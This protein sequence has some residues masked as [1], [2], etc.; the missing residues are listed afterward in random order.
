M[1][2]I[3]DYWNYYFYGQEIIKLSPCSKY[4]N[5]ESFVSILQKDGYDYYLPI[6]YS[7]IKI[8]YIPAINYH[9]NG[10]NFVVEFDNKNTINIDSEPQVQICN[11]N[12]DKEQCFMIKFS[13][14]NFP[15][16]PISKMSEFEINLTIIKNSNKYQYIS[17]N[18]SIYNSIKYPL[19][20]DK[21]LFADRKDI[22]LCFSG[23]GPRSFSATLGYIR[24]LYRMNVLKDVKYV[25]SVSGATWAW[26]PYTFLDDGTNEEKFIGYDIFGDLKKVLTME[27]INYTDEQYFGNSLISKAYNYQLIEYIYDAVM[28]LDSGEKSRIWAYM[29]GKILLEPYGL[30]E[31]NFFAPNQKIADLFNED[32]L[33]TN[34]HYKLPYNNQRPFIITN[35]GVVKPDK[36]G[37]L[38]N[39][40]FNLIEMTPLYSGT[41]STLKTKDGNYGGHYTN[42]YGF[43]PNQFQMKEDNIAEVKLLANNNLHNISYFNLFDMMGSSS[44]AYGII[45]DLLGL[46][47]A[48]PS[49][50]L[51]DT[52]KNEVKS[53]DCIDG[54]VLD[55]AGILPMLQ[56]EVKK[57]V[58]FVNTN[59]KINVSGDDTEM[60]KSI[61]I[62]I[63][64]LFLGDEEVD[65]QWYFRYFEY[66]CD[67]QV[68]EKSRWKELLDQMRNN[69]K[70]NEIA[71]VEMENLKVLKN[72]N[73][74]I[75]EYV[76]EKL[77][78][79]YLY[80][81]EDWKNNRLDKDV[82]DYLK[83][84]EIKNFPYYDTVFENNGW[85]EKE[86]I[87]LTAPEVNLLS[88][89]TYHNMMNN[90]IINNCFMKLFE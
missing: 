27:E 86:I 78:I 7:I 53:F 14:I 24:A 81:T 64:Q 44:T 17:L 31:T 13:S 33:N 36:R 72:D 79:V 82:Q 51:A 87:S 34:Q 90:R 3:N 83:K 77:Q 4:L 60:T 68:F 63:R 21:I 69:I 28:N 85:I 5:G 70:E 50:R 16:I 49:Y 66:I 71:F 39:T 58:L 15:K 12:Y 9:D 74:H 25:S 38:T 32:P 47:Y 35:T 73:F 22:G 6:D 62:M 57:I 18:T 75:P 61:D 30:L 52:E 29:L 56:R 76:V 2:Y 80:E 8:E 48:N 10:Y 19:N 40:D 11:I 20:I 45:T 37:T 46:S 1:N 59:N 89:L 23:G 55:N 26:V 67:L 43:N 41:L 65:K 88:D 42:T 84:G 54:G